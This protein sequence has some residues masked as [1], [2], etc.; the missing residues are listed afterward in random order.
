M[1]ES[2]PEWK[3]EF[4]SAWD[5]IAGVL[6]R[7]RERIKRFSLEGLRG[8]GLAERALSMV[9]LVGELE[10]PDADRLDGYHEAELE[11][12]KFNLFSPAPV[13]R[14]FEALNLETAIRYSLKHLPADSE[15]R[16]ILESLGD[17]QQAA[18]KL[19]GETQL[20]DPAFRK[21]LVEGGRA[22]VEKSTDPL[23]VLARR[24]APLAV[25]NIKWMKKNVE[26]VTVPAS[27]KIGRARFAVYGKAVYPDATFSLR[28]S[29]GTVRGYP[30]N[31]TLAPA[32]TTLY[33]LYD[34]A[35][36]FAGR[37]EWEL[38][39]RYWERQ[40]RLDLS[41]PVNFVSDCD[42]IGGNSGSPV[43]DRSG[44]LVGLVFDGNI[45]S[46]AGRYFFDDT[47]NRTVAVHAAF[48]IEALRK[49]Y[50]AEDLADEI[51]MP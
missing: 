2:R 44:R 30:M 38:P 43:V 23:I 32:R 36:G 4:A 17:P 39:A 27:E 50:D 11:R 21:Q 48:I 12:L 41:T 33:G 18:E 14:D 46:L 35:L 37:P 24:L 20:V 29:Y 7:H 40:E 28:L 47:A 9:I 34:R 25:E 19:C 3:K 45:E 13:Y 42:I 15:W 6:S 31:G 10:K 26:S 1:V 8:S 22:A 49:L 16:K 5:D 51:E